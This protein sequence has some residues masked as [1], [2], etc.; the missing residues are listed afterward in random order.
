MII[1]DFMKI[2]TFIEKLLQKK[3]KINQKRAIQQRTTILF[4]FSIARAEKTF[5]P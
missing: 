1:V 3:K 2:F 5:L 4:L